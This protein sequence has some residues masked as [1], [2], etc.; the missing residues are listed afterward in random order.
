M[1]KK[2]YSGM[3][4]ISVFTLVIT[5]IVIFSASYY[6]FGLRIQDEVKADAINIAEY[7][8]NDDENCTFRELLTEKTVSVISSN[9][10]ILFCSDKR[11]LFKDKNEILNL[12]SVQKILNKNSGSTEQC[13]TGYFKKIYNC[14]TV[15]PDGRIVTVSALIVDLLS[16]FSEIFV[17]LLLVGVLIFVFS[18]MV[19]KKLTENIILPIE[20]A[21]LDGF[22]EEK[23]P[24]EELKPFIR[25]IASQNAEI[26]RQIDRVKRQKL[27][28][29]AVSESMN[30]GLVVLDREGSILSVN[31]SA[32]NFFG[33]SGKEKYTKTSIMS[34]T[35]KD[36]FFADNIVKALHNERGSFC[37]HVGDKSYDVFY[38]PV[39]D[40]DRVLGVVILMFDI[41]EKLKNEQIRAEFTANVS[42]ELRTPLTSIHGYAQL[43]SGGIAR[44]ED[45]ETFA[46]RIEK[47]S[48]RLIRLVEDIVELSNLDEGAE[49]NKT[50]FSV[51]SMVCD[52]A[53]GLRVNA[54]KRS[55]T[56]NVSGTD[57]NLFADSKRIHEL[58]Y[59]IIEN[60]VKYNKDNGTVDVLV[61]DHV[62]TVKDTGIGIPEEYRS[63]IFERFFRVDKSHSKKVNGTGLGLS[64]VKHIAMNNNIKI[65]VDST[66]GVGS[67]FTIKFN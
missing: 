48:S 63:R 21:S 7:I 12:K 31:N 19:S 62:I 1:F 51:Y 36:P 38:S 30:E 43:L 33:T 3:K 58:L 18:G 57:F 52:I 54:E 41:T 37:Y 34:L 6:I 8:K 64:I 29:Q 60:A 11:E 39:S 65:D 47:E 40:E 55:I 13:T 17:V 23:L 9:G 4:L 67:C 42:H 20:K 45:I 25:R 24:Y 32:M 46:S 5:A 35:G 50:N 14:S 56:I 44:G 16:L 22:N 66:P 2:I 15:L 61:S 53:E 27:R 10:E 28:L 26:K 49:G 59:N